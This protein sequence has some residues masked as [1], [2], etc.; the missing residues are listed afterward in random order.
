M[1]NTE[2]VTDGGVQEKN[3]IIAAILSWFIPGIGQI[4]AG[5]TKRGGVWLAIWIAY[6]V[7]AFVLSF[8][9]VGLLLFFIE[10][11]LHLAPAYDAYDQT[12]KVNTGE[13]Q[14]GTGEAQV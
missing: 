13:T 4:Y 12:Q 10:P 1:S 5:Q 8:I 7:V 9:G 2:L 14:I 11:L 6:V 3:P